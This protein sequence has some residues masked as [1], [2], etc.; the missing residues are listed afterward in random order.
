MTTQVITAPEKKESE[1]RVKTILGA[2]GTALLAYHG[3]RHE[4]KNYPEE[5]SARDI[6]EYEAFLWGACTY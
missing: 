6:A 2:I 3:L 1:S 5:L 4:A